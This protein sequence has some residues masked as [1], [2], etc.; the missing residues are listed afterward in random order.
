M[1]TPA[2]L[3]LGALLI[4]SLCPPFTSNDSFYTVP[5]A[6]AILHHGTTAVDEFVPIAPAA[7]HYAVECV[8]PHGPAVSYDAANGCPGGHWYNAYPLGPSLL[9][10]PFI[11]IIQLIASAISTLFP[12]AHFLIAQPVIS[13]FL[14]GDLFGA[15]Q[16]AELWSAA[17][18]AALSALFVY[19][20]TLRF[21]PRRQALLL[22]L[23][24]AFGTTQWST[25]SRSLWQHGPSV[26]CLALTLYLLLQPRPEFAAI[27]L[28]LSFI[29]RPSNF[30]AVAVLTVYVAVHHR[31]RLLRFLAC[32][33]PVAAL[34]FLY[35]LT[36]LHSL[37]PRYFHAGVQTSKPWLWGVAMNLVSPSRGLLIFTPVFLFA[38]AGA[39]LAFTRPFRLPLACY[40]TVIVL[41]HAALLGNYWGGHCYG[42]RYFSDMAPFLIFLLIPAAQ[43]WNKL[44]VN[45]LADNELA[46]NKPGSNKLGPNKLGSNK[47]DSN[48]LAVNKRAAN[49]P[50]PN[51]LA[52]NNLAANQLAD[53]K[54]ADNKLTANLAPNNLAPNNL[55]AK[56]LADDKPA[57]NKLTA[58]K[59]TANKLAP[60]NLA[61]N[62]LAADS[63]A[64]NQ[65]AGNKPGGAGFSLRNILQAAFLATAAWGL[66]LHAEGAISVK[67]QNW[68][69][70]PNEIDRHM[71]RVWSWSDPQ[72]LRGLK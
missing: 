68:N 19:L 58:N 55:A 27:P 64:A 53:D 44:G 41:C 12:R 70:T 50:A 60:N 66:L 17:P 52:P 14:R 5:T 36:V 46:G 11:A 45:E 9:A 61:A 6:L 24:F 37:L 23:I 25:A 10:L 31:D 30:I 35:N 18:I 72:W 32:A 21:L 54:P 40:L 20:T 67:A 15:H 7:S 3:F 65:L 2:L 49:K 8:P 62:Q 29:A 28:A 57:D 56:Q 13:A 63:L 39:A 16:L 71:D 43:Y 22:A 59:L 51:K 33:A 47:L 26:L 48:D 4:Y 42:P 34:F 69:D 38:I 1:K